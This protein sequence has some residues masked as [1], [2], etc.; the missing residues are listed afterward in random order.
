M[1]PPMPRR[2]ATRAALLGAA[3]ALAACS[4]RAPS[5]A[6]L[7]EPADT[8]YAVCAPDP[9]E[10]AEDCACED[11]ADKAARKSA[12]APAPPAPAATPATVDPELTHFLR[13]LGAACAVKDLAHLERSV[14]FPLPWRTIVNENVDEGAP[15]TKRRRIESAADLCAEGVFAG[16]QGVDPAFPGDPLAIAEDGPKCRVETVVGQFGATIVLEKTDR[17]WV[18]AAIDAGG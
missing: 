7:P 4:D 10:I 16:V 17:G 1:L 13:D 2:R 11:P 5:T 3:C 15:V 12:T 6:P 14:R 18:L 9:D 8:A